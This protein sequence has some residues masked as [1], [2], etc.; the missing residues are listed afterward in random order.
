M[1]KRQ[2][3]RCWRGIQRAA[4]PP[5]IWPPDG[6]VTSTKPVT[7]LSAAIACTTTIPPLG[8]STPSNPCP[9]Q[10]VAPATVLDGARDQDPIASWGRRQISIRTYGRGGFVL[11]MGLR[12]RKMAREGASVGAHH[13]VA[14]E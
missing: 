4:N 2:P 12:A 8:H 7:V 13:G 9:A 11:E 5:R 10:R 3:Q 14:A 1:L 6:K